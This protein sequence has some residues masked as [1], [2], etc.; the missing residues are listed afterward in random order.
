VPPAEVI[1][2][3]EKIADLHGCC[4]EDAPGSG[5]PPTLCCG[6]TAVKRLADH[7]GDRCTALPCDRAD[8]LIALVVDEDLQP[9]RQYTHTLACIYGAAVTVLRSNRGISLSW[10]NDRTVVICGYGGSA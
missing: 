7:V 8:P 1:Q 9:M 2:F 4:G 5:G 6:Q 10:A 3:G